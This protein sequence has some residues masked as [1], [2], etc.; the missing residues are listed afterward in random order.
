MCPLRCPID[1]SQGKRIVALFWLHEEEWSAESAIMRSY[2]S[3]L[4]FFHNELHNVDAENAASR[5]RIHE[6]M[7]ISKLAETGALVVSG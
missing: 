1:A 5:L 6:L 3:L 2:R 4:H 7:H